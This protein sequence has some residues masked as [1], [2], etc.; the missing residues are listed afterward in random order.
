[1]DAKEA[2]VG[3]HVWAHVKDSMLVDGQIMPFEKNVECVIQELGRDG[4]ECLLRFAR[5]HEI[6]RG[7]RVAWRNY[8][9][10][11]PVG[12][13]AVFRKAAALL[14]N[15]ETAKAFAEAWNASGMEIEIDM[16][17]PDAPWNAQEE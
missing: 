13:S 7:V 17:D 16:S 1:M 3:M 14:A 10:I 6:P 11:A 5:P 4:K 15:P 9:D 2:T 8:E 12:E